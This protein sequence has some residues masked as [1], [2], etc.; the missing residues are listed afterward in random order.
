MEDVARDTIMLLLKNKLLLP[1]QRK[2]KK[3]KPGKKKLVK[4]PRTLEPA[5]VSSAWSVLLHFMI[6][7][8]IKYHRP[9]TSSIETARWN[10]IWAVFGIVCDISL[11]SSPG[12]DPGINLSVVQSNGKGELWT[13]SE[14][15]LIVVSWWM[16]RRR[17]M[18][19]QRPLQM[20]VR[21]TNEHA[22]NV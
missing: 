22:N 18:K 21:L 13:S 10:R 11:V 3:A 15:H 19:R 14:K 17:Y 2:F 20:L 5:T 16:G 1:C 6:H 4:W 7:H 8:S 12:M 9:G